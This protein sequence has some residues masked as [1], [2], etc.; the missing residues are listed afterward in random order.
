[1]IK[2][3]VSIL[4]IF[5][6]LFM[7]CQST[8]NI[9]I[10]KQ[11]SISYSLEIRERGDTIYIVSKQMKPLGAEKTIATIYRQKKGEKF[12]FDGDKLREEFQIIIDSNEK[13]KSTKYY[14]LKEYGELESL[15]GVVQ[16]SEKKDKLSYRFFNRYRDNDD[17]Q[18]ILKSN[19]KN[20]FKMYDNY[21]RHVK[22]VYKFESK[23]KQELTHSKNWLFVW[24]FCNGD[25][26]LKKDGSLWRFGKMYCDEGRISPSDAVEMYH[27]YL[28]PKKIGEKFSGAKIK[29]AGNFI[30]AI[31]RDGTLW[32]RG[33][34]LDSKAIQIG[35]DND[36]VDF[37]TEHVIHEGCDYKI[38]LKKDG[39][40]WKFSYDEKRII[41]NPKKMGKRKDWDKVYITYCKIY[42]QH[43]DGSYWVL[44][45]DDTGEKEIVSKVSAKDKAILK[46]K[47]IKSGEIKSDDL[48]GYGEKVNRD[49]TLWLL[50]QIEYRELEPYIIKAEPVARVAP[51]V[52]PPIYNL[53]DKKKSKKG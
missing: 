47:D 22:R 30:H 38:G 2:K 24:N 37:G 12:F 46:M 11:N 36:W 7:G 17:M 43:K 33:N 18:S 1:M 23:K 21:I 14:I 25:I 4:L 53:A 27:Y 50:P 8:K 3:K 42:L 31:K 40:V 51:L 6:F 52:A 16:V 35:K 13:I 44:H 26:A 41:G 48:G 39:S 28:K 34:K 45:N 20:R 19:K 32:V 29:Q 5:M 15:F 10:K 49:G 9:P